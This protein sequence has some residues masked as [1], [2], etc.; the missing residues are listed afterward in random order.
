MRLYPDLPRRRATTVAGDAAL[1]LAV[2]LFAWL[3]TVVHGAVEDLTVVSRGVEDAGSS[4]EG[5]LGRAGDAVG[6]APIVGGQLG[7]A[8]RDAGAG[9]GGRAAATA[10][11]GDERIRA[12]ADLGGWLTFLLPTALLLS[13]ALPPRVGQVRRLTAASRVLRA[14]AD[15]ERRLLLAQ[16]A[17]FGLPFATLLRHTPDPLGDLAAGRLDG[18]VAAVREDAGLAA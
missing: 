12:L 13:R 7:D 2:L 17:A 1:L 18:L 3:G 6:G 14:P 11:E 5:A 4:V 10:R 9:T 16:R 8:L 15:D